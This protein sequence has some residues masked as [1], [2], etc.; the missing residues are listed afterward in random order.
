MTTEYQWRRS[1][2]VEDREA[3]V[4]VARAAAVRAWVEDAAREWAVADLV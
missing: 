1:I 4:V 2:C 3:A